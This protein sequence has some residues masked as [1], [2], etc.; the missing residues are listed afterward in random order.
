[1]FKQEQ[2]KQ[3]AVFPF[4]ISSIIKQQKPNDHEGLK[5]KFRTAANI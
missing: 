1:M 4:L 2:T 3:E 5:P